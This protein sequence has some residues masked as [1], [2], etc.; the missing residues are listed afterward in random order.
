MANVSTI[1]HSAPV[2]CTICTCHREGCASERVCVYLYV[3]V[4]CFV[5][6][7]AA[8]V[9]GIMGLSKISKS[10]RSHVQGLRKQKFHKQKEPRSSPM[11]TLSPIFEEETTV[12]SWTWDEEP[13]RVGSPKSPART[14]QNPFRRSD[15]VMAARA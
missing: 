15:S 11:I 14:S 4:L 7:A 9:G 2:N 3:C 12:R 6:A 5:A 10:K 1:L 13:T 8:W